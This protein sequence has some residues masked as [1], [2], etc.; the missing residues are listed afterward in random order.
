MRFSVIVPLYN[1]GPYL[2]KALASVIAQTFR[3]FELIVVDD[4]STDD[5]FQVAQS[6]LKTADVKHQIGRAHV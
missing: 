2:S 6:V 5:S 4:G 1:K 3:D